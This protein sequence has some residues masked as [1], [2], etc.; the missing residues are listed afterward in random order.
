MTEQYDSLKLKHLINERM[1][2]PH[3]N[4]LNSPADVEFMLQTFIS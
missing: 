4:E 1:I 2:I 3:Q